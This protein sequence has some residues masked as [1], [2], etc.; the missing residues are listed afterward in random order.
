MLISCITLE[1]PSSNR[2]AARQKNRGA[3]IRACPYGL[4]KLFVCFCLHLAAA[5]CNSTVCVL[6]K[7][8]RKISWLYALM[9]QFLTTELWKWAAE[10]WRVHWDTKTRWWLW[11]GVRKVSAGALLK[12]LVSSAWGENKGSVIEW[13]VGRVTEKTLIFQCRTGLKLFSA[14][15][16]VRDAFI[17]FYFYLFT[18]LFAYCLFSALSHEGDFLVRYIVCTV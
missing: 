5:L 12:C 18:S 1:N 3:L 4:L 17:Y 16:E 15:E 13:N 9:F 6:R 14:P 7:E 2:Y 10:T 11:P 8:T